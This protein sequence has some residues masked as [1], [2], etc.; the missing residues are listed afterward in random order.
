MKFCKTIY[1]I[2]FLMGS[3]LTVSCKKEF[4]KL[5]NEETDLGGKALLKV[6]NGAV[7]TNRNYVYIDNIPVTGSILA[8]GALFP[9]TGYTAT[10]E[11]GTRSVVV[12]DTLATT[13]QNAVTVSSNF[14]AGKNYTLFTYDTVNAV[15]AK[16]VPDEIEIP[17]DTT[18]R[19]RFVNL[20]FNST[21]LPNV[22]LFSTRRNANI[23]SN[24]TLAQVTNFIPYASNSVDTLYVRATGTT[25]N[26]TPLFAIRPT[27]KRSYTVVYR[28]RY[29]TTT[30]STAALL[31]SLTSFASR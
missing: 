30:P 13:T 8:Y 1:V 31:R 10:V 17:A 22:D 15:K 3:L 6:F 25:T 27:Q 4:K 21:P 23:F 12:K 26:L 14:E 7:N 19:L 5:V 28:G 24:V 29:G 20:I 11:P 2:S 9:S 18:A 16:L